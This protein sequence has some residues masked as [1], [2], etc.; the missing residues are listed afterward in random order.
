VDSNFTGIN[1]QKTE[2][3]N[4]SDK[5]KEQKKQ[6]QLILLF[7]SHVH[8]RARKKSATPVGALLLPLCCE[9]LHATATPQGVQDQV[10]RG[11]ERGESETSTSN[12]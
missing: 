8:E 3:Q 5:K 6:E 7:G 9:Y 1:H 2:I 10:P 11:G 12:T 4:P